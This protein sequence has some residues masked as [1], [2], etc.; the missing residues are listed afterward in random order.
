MVNYW[1][2]QP[3]TML[4]SSST[5]HI[6]SGYSGT[7]CR[8]R[9]SLGKVNSFLCNIQGFNDFNENPSQVATLIRHEFGTSHDFPGGLAEHFTPVLMFPNVSQK[10][11]PPPEAP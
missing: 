2:F 3:N 5:V 1:Q 8:K 6:H 9:T 10:L 11:S 4:S 7:L